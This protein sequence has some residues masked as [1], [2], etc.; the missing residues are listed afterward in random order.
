MLEINESDVSG[1]ILRLS[2]L[3]WILSPLSVSVT[4]E[5][6]WPFESAEYMGLEGGGGE[7]GPD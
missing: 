3:A 5:P 4:A 7:P 1:R 2:L 6:Q